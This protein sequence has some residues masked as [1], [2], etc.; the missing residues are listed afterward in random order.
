MSDDLVKE[1]QH[2]QIFVG[3]QAIEVIAS[4]LTSEQFYGYCLGNFLKYR[5]RAGNKGDLQEDINKAEFYK[6]LYDM[7]VHL[8]RK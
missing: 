3:T 7:Y 4:T 5:L 1:P 2:Y 8:C 6:E